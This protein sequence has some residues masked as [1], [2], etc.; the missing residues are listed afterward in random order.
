MTPQIVTA[1]ARYPVST[2]E[3]RDQLG[4]DAR[5]FDAFHGGLIAAATAA[6]ETYLNRALITRTYVA[7][8]DRWPHHGAGH[9]HPA[10]ANPVAGLWRCGPRWIELPRA[11][12]QAVG[13]VKTYDDADVATTW[14]DTDYYV[15]TRSTV[16]RIVL[17]AGA[18]W[19]APTRVA[20]GIE[21]QWTAGMGDNPADVPEDIRLGILIVIAS[22]NEQRGDELTP[23]GLPEPA[24]ALLGPHRLIP[25]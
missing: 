2:A 10:Y 22:L 11:P 21:I 8:L 3:V 4:I 1:P 15:D 17:R 12:L 6:V 19:P 25:V 20:N 24:T 18:S 5:D 16:G 13:F 9:R 23:K 14:A 7:N